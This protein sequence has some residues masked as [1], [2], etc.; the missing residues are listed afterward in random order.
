MTSELLKGMFV[1]MGWRWGG[2]ST[3]LNIRILT[4]INENVK[5]VHLW[6]QEIWVFIKL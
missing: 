1:C 4:I 2:D 5:S 6:I 3:K